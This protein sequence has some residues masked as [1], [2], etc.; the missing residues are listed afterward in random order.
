MHLEEGVLLGRVDTARAPAVQRWEFN[1]P[2]AIVTVRG[3]EFVLDVPAT[4]ETY[5][6]VLKGEVE[7]QPAEGPQG[8]PPSIRVTTNQEAIVPRAKGA[9]V[10]PRFNA[11]MLELAR[12]HNGL[13][14]RQLH[15]QGI[16][17]PFTPSYRKELRL[18]FV[19]PVPVRA[20][21]PPRPP[22]KPRPPKPHPVRKVP[23]HDSSV[24]DL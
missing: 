11:P 6:G 7:V 5:V 13:I 21:R 14:N 1:T 17:S 4:K 9:K 3:T 23:G 12:L 19:K 8:L 18:K 16:Y 24:N 10:L 15:A 20:P 2:T 22:R